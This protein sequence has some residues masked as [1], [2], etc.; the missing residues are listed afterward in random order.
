[1]V[2]EATEKSTDEVYEILLLEKTGDKVPALND[3]PDKFALADKDLVMISLYVLVTPFSARTAIGISFNPK[4][5]LTDLLVLLA[6]E[7]PLIRI[8]AVASKRTGRIE[9]LD[10]LSATVAVYS[11]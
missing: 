4:L 3:K 11:N 7:T 5:K 10:T 9:R 8:E 6:L 2:S 1:M